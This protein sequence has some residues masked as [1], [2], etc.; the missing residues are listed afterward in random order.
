MDVEWQVGDKIENKYEVH[1][2]KKGG[3]GIVYLC[4]DHE[5]MVPIAVKTFQKGLFSNQKVR[6]DFTKE[7]LTWVKLD[8]HKNIVKAHYVKNIEGRPYIFLEYVAGGN[9]DDW[10]YTKQLDLPLALNFAIQFCNGMDYAYEK[11]GLIHRDIKP[12]NILLTND[13]T[14]KITDFG[15]SKTIEAKPEQMEV[16]QDISYAQSS[17][18][19]TPLYMA[20]EQFTGQKIDTR[21]DIYA[22]GIVLY[23]MVANSYPYSR[24]KFW[25]VMHLMES[26]LPIKQ[27]IPLELNVLI[28]RCL[29]KK[30]SRR[31]QK[32][33]ELKQELSKIYFDLTGEKIIEDSPEEL[34]L[35]ELGNKGVALGNLGKYQEASTCFD[36]AIE[37]NS[38][39]ADAW[40][41]KGTVQV[42]LG[43]HREALAC[44]DKALEI[45]PRH[46]NAWH[47]KGLAL[48]NLVRHQEAIACFDKAIEINSRYA[49]AWSHKGT[50]LGKLG[51]HQEAIACFDEALEINPRDAEIWSN[52]G[53]ELTNLGRYQEAF[54]CF[55]RAIEI[56]PLFDNAWTSKGAALGKLGKH[57]EAIACFDEAVEINPRDTIIW[58]NKGDALVNLGRHQEAIACFDMAIE[59][60]SRNVEAWSN[61]GTALGKLGRH[62]EALACF[63]KAL[64]INP[65]DAKAWYNKGL[66]LVILGRHQEAISPFQKFIDIAPPQCAARIRKVEEAIHQFK[67]SY[68]NTIEI[69]SRN[70][71]AWSNK[72]TALGE[73]SKHQEALAYFDKALEINPRDAV[74]LYNKGNALFH[75]GMQQDAL[76][77][78]D[79]A[80]EMNPRD[81]AAWSN[82]GTALGNWGR[83]QEAL[84]CFN[85]AIEINPRDAEAW[86]N[87]GIM[88]GVLGR[89]YEAIS[90]LQKFIELTSPQYTSQVKKAEEVIHRLKGA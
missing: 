76:A 48:F 26:P 17:V 86:N 75:L 25:L 71:E 52:K 37:I 1:D 10:L 80:L 53:N 57:Q 47:N 83:Y 49:G 65:R 18:A 79:S 81:A 68:D 50:A 56:N 66:G 88:L 67:G 28:H 5:S 21:A 59:I 72:G 15:L 46:A 33:G 36:K 23:Q 64:E 24:N 70:V 34:D 74:T 58:N 44:F 27:N 55:N 45:N 84:E 30:P 61:K 29:E 63:D 90:S 14:V 89:S 19:G 22:F 35:W 9:L 38:R 32:F 60:N 40:S 31:Y 85:K 6:D 11:M 73:L 78:Y 39:Y 62:Q 51:K 82:K 54:T 16:P 69:N 13:K 3:F 42:K 43:L 8:K 12:A 4:Y 87:R 20:P 41:N 77:C 7:A 2:I